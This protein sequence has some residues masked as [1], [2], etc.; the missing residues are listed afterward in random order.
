LP[1]KFYWPG[2]YD[3]YDIREAEGLSLHFEDAKYGSKSTR[4]SSFSLINIELETRY[5][6]EF[7]LICKELI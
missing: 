7:R 5:K 3:D 1:F 6:S 4:K 2:V